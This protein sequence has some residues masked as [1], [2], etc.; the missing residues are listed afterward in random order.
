VLLPLDVLDRVAAGEVTVAFRSWKRPTVKAGGTLLTAVGQLA[1]DAVD[2]IDPAAI[3]D[4]DARAAGAAD[5]DDLRSWLRAEPGRTTYRIAFHLAGPDPRIA[6]RS[7]STLTADEAAS[8]RARLDGWDRRS[9]TGPWTRDV[10]GAIADRPGVVSTELAESLGQDRARFKARVRQ[11]KG[12]GL[13]ESLEVGYR[14]SPRGAALR[15][16]LDDAP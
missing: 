14:L 2:P 16:A 13:T 1:I 7:A 9:P 3:T 10:L 4:A 15:S 12:L 6:L 11:L 8:L 5:A